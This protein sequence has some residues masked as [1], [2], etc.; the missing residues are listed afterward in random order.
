MAKEDRFIVIY[1]DNKQDYRSCI[2]DKKTNKKYH[3]LEEIA[4]LL[5]QIGGV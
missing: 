1:H 2:Q 4:K 5:N 3:S